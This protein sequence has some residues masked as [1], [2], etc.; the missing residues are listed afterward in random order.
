MNEQ[1]I[2]AFGGGTNTFNVDASDGSV[3]IKSSDSGQRLEIDGS[4]NQLLLVVGL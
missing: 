4:T 1:G 2:R 3:T